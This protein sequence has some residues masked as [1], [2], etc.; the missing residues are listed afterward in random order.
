LSKTINII[1]KISAAAALKNLTNDY[2]YKKRRSSV[3]FVFSK[4]LGLT[5]PFFKK[6]NRSVK[7]TLGK[8]IN[9]CGIKAYFCQNQ[10][11]QGV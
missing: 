10:E 2:V 1:D 4:I 7:K 5:A 11:V 3:T 6:E 9:E 8:T